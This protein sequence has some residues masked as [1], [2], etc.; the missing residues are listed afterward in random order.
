MRLWREVIFGTLEHGTG[1]ENWFTP[2]HYHNLKWQNQGEGVKL[3]WDRSTK[4]KGRPN[5]APSRLSD[6]C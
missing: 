4:R 5:G 3:S 2:E 1:P 6:D